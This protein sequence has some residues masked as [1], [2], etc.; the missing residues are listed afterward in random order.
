MESGLQ[1]ISNSV[2]RTRRAGRLAIE[3][4][5]VW[6]VAPRAHQAVAPQQRQMLRH[7]GITQLEELRELADGSLRL[8]QLAQDQQPMPVAER[9]Q[10][11]ARLVGGG[12]HVRRGRSSSRSSSYLHIYDD[13]NI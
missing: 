12:G 3:Y 9:A 1:K 10:Q 8:G 6:P 2:S 11:F 5:M 7:G 13:T 4:Q